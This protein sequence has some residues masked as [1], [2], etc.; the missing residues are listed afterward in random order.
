MV[1]TGRPDRFTVNLNEF[2][3]R[4]VGPI[5]VTDL[6]VPGSLPETR[7]EVDPRRAASTRLCAPATPSSTARSRPTEGARAR[8]GLGPRGLEARRRRADLD[9]VGAR[10]VPERHLVGPEVALA[11]AAL[12][13]GRAASGALQRSESLPPDQVVTAFSGVDEVASV[14]VPPAETGDARRPAAAASR[15]LRGALPVGRTVVPGGNDPRALGVHF[16][17]FDYRAP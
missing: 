9:D 17:G 5:Y 10:A 1:W 4:S 3:S 14:R 7:V 12:R 2:F 6:G 13:R 15:R 11:A 16:N 8:R